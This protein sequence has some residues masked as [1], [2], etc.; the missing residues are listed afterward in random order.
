MLSVLLLAATLPLGV[1]PV[2]AGA[3]ATV[4]DEVE[5]YLVEPDEDYY[6]LAVQPL[7]PRLARPEPAALK[8]LAALAGRLGAD[9]VLLLGELDE[10]AIPDDLDEPLRPGERF[11]AAVFIAFDVA[12]DEAPG[13]TL[14]RAVLSLRVPHAS[15]PRRRMAPVH[16]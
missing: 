7:A 13:P 15:S 12:A 8:R 9:A 14:T 1:W 4:V 5:F 2:D 3:A 16:Q 10:A 11:V 6:I